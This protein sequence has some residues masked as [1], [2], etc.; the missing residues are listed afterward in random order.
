MMALLSTFFDGIFAL[1]GE[2]TA[3]C[4]S[5]QERSTPF[6]N[7]ALSPWVMAN[8]INVNFGF[9]VFL[10]WAAYCETNLGMKVLWF[11]LIMGLGNIAMSFYVLIQIWRLKPGQPVSAI[12]LKRSAE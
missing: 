6:P 3:R 11:I 5:V 10:I 7:L 12:L 2:I 4:S 9:I 1:I 8:I